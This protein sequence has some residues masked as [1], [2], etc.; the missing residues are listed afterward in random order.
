MTT[1][2][3]TDEWFKHRMPSS[4]SQWQSVDEWLKSRSPFYNYVKD[5]EAYQLAIR[6]PKELSQNEGLLALLEQFGRGLASNATF[7]ASK[8]IIGEKQPSTT[9]Q[10]I[11]KGL[12][13]FAGFLV[14]YGVAAKAVGVGMKGLKLVPKAVEA[15][16]AI[17]ASQRGSAI[18]SHLLR[19]S[20]TLG[21]AEAISNITEPNTML[22]RAIHG[23]KIG[24]IFGGTSFADLPNHRFFGWLLRQF[25]GRAALAIAGEYK[26]AKEMFDKD[27][28]A[29]TVFSEA[30]ATF[31]LSHRIT[32]EEILDPTRMPLNK[33]AI[34][35]LVENQ[36]TKYNE[37]ERPGTAIS[38]PLESLRA[39]RITKMR[40]ENL[41]PDQPVDWNSNVV[42]M[43]RNRLNRNQKI[44]RVDVEFDE[45]SGKY[46]AKDSSALLKAIELS[47]ADKKLNQRRESIVTEVPVRILKE[48]PNAPTPK[49]PL[50]WQVAMLM[51][52]KRWN[53]DLVFR[54]NQTGIFAINVDTMYPRPLEYSSQLAE[55]LGPREI[56]V[57]K[58]GTD[59]SGR[60]KFI[61]MGRGRLIRPFKWQDKEIPRTHKDLVLLASLKTGRIKWEKQLQAVSSDP[62]LAAK[63]QAQIN[64][65]DKMILKVE[66]KLANWHAIQDAIFYRKHPALP[67]TLP[68]AEWLTTIS[69]KKPAIKLP[70]GEM[71]KSGTTRVGHVDLLRQAIADKKISE[72]GLIAQ[73]GDISDLNKIVVPMRGFI[74]RNN[75]VSVDPAQLRTSYEQ[76]VQ[77]SRQLVKKMRETRKKV[78]QEIDIDK[79]MRK[80]ES[81][82][83]AFYKSVN[84]PIPASSMQSIFKRIENL[85]IGIEPQVFFKF[86][87]V[88]RNPT[89]E[90]IPMIE[91]FLV[92]LE[93]LPLGDRLPSLTTNLM[94]R[95]G[96]SIPPLKGDMEEL[97]LKHDAKIR[98]MRE[99][100]LKIALWKSKHVRNA[101]PPI[102]QLLTLSKSWL[103]ADVLK[104]TNHLQVRTGLPLYDITM[105]ALRAHATKKA[106]LS[107]YSNIL[108]KFSKM[109]IED[110]AKVGLYY[111]AMYLMKDVPPGLTDVHYNFIKA[112][113]GIMAELKP[114]VADARFQRWYQEVYIKRDPVTRAPQPN[115]PIIFKSQKKMESFLMEGARHF[116]ETETAKMAGIEEPVLLTAYGRW[117]NGPGLELGGIYSGAYLPRFILNINQVR[118]DYAK[119]ASELGNIGT[120]HIKIRDTA[121]PYD[122]TGMLLGLEQTLMEKN[123]PARLYGYI[124]QILNLKYIQPHIEALEAVANLFPDEFMNAK[125]K[126]IGRMAP[127]AKTLSL[128][129]YLEIFAHRL[130]GYPVKLGPIGEFMR[131]LQS[132]F[133]RTLTPR[134]F[135]WLRNLPQC[136]VTVPLKA[137]VL[138][139]KFWGARFKALPEDLQQKFFNDG[140]NMENE[141][142]NDFLQLASTER[143]EKLPFIGTWFKIAEKVGNIYTLTDI[144]NRKIVYSR[145]AHRALHYLNEY[146]NNRIAAETLSNKLGV[147]MMED[148]AQK[149]FRIAVSEGNYKQAAFEVAKWQTDN[150]QWVYRR[151]EKS[152]AEMTPEGEA[153]TNL[154]TWAKGISQ[155]TLGALKRIYD[156]WEGLYGGKSKAERL[157]GS[158]LMLSGASQIAGVM[159]AGMVANFALRAVTGTWR[160]RFSGYGVDMFT[161]DFGGVTAEIVTD[162]SKNM[163]TLISSLEGSPDE[164]IRARDAFLKYLDNTMVRQLLPFAKQALAVVE[165]CTGRSYIAP[166]SEKI[167]RL[168][169]GYSAGETYV[170]RTLLE[171]IAHAIT[172]ADPAKQESARKWVNFKKHELMQKVASGGKFKAINSMLLKYYEH[173]DSVLERYAPMELFKDK[174]QRE[175]IKSM[176]SLK[177][178]AIQNEFFGEWYK[179]EK[180]V[181]LAKR[182][183]QYYGE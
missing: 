104:A 123:L 22:S 72:Q 106:M 94:A 124:N 121:A 77:D 138:D 55:R 82:L 168:T 38:I 26:P 170:Q 12:G 4:V 86:I 147:F 157:E 51:K 17:T 61:P 7:G 96:L 75:F 19:S 146:K 81:L 120:G 109:S 127:E 97:Q 110:Q 69:T 145:A 23:A 40:V 68:F 105:K 141:L 95:Y 107:K 132:V 135:L 162:F 183:G 79:F 20:A 114:I 53:T 85:G 88:K 122:A 176:E 144:F 59:P 27:N 164:R 119:T 149:L 134:P 58:A 37:G 39:P 163:S 32:P 41:I 43:H 131:Q 48:N 161:W 15:G 13:E 118:L 117:I 63:A 29:Q 73:F 36:I 103:W 179:Q 167:G 66:K 9:A 92:D 64:R 45:V 154:L 126:A 16:K 74:Y 57:Q 34:I 42:R 113:D 165:S 181:G 62:E 160:T 46:M 142:R 8:Y 18:L 153:W 177:P 93:Q 28:I 49:L 172:A 21:T 155:Q 89:L 30:L 2:L 115:E 6:P 91:G 83:N 99:K 14:P 3:S 98:E 33:Q 112:I 148:G 139:P 100:E 143:L 133:F 24:A 54:I 87:G 150:S 70:N 175:F 129:D 128:H 108:D 31:F 116:E 78:T 159:L 52:A 169:R 35:K 102:Q 56:L 166:I 158:R 171:G 140:V 50:P 5:W 60:I 44:P 130:K 71:V 173:L 67:R 156:G 137:N 10:H 151:T 125:T 80:T 136:V 182:L 11:A 25:G 174:M 90:N 76:Y 178:E 84:Y 152:L 101:G 65:L 47:N 180:A 111:E 1:W